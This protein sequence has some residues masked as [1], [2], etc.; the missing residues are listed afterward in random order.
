MTRS[1]DLASR[2]RTR[3]PPEVV[4]GGAPRALRAG[5][6]REIGH[7]EGTAG[8]ERSRQRRTPRPL[9]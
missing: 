6:F 7:V 8:H 9:T 4:Q 3:V 1:T 5:Y 2:R